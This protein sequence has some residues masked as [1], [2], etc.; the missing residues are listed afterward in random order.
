MTKELQALKIRLNDGNYCERHQKRKSVVATV[1]AV[2]VVAHTQRQQ[3]S[4]RDDW[5]VN[6]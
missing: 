3:C 6:L 1:V 4:S 5:Q 2:A